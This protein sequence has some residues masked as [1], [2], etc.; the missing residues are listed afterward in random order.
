MAFEHRILDF[1][2]ASARRYGDIM[3]SRKEMGRPLSSLDWKIIA[4]ARTNT[5]A[6]ATRNIRNFELRRLTIVNPFD[7]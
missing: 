7:S 1:D 2:E 5:C 3:E 4:I 6:V